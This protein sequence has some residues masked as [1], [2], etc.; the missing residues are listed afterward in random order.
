MKPVAAAI[1]LALS[2]AAGLAAPGLAGAQ[3]YPIN[4]GYWEVTTNWLGLVKKTERWCVAPKAIPRF[5]AGPCNH[6]YHCT[7]PVQ[8]FH[9]GHAHFEG[10]IRGHD[11]LYHV[12]GG[13]TYSPTTMDMKVVGAG[14][15]HI[16]PIVGASASLNAHFL[17][18]ACPADAKQV[19]P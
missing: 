16:V 2:F 13:G 1:A 12:K 4:P 7:Y 10:D 5:L 9:D 18:P 3:P 11:E 14:H 17:A 19:K 8:E 15:W 6:I